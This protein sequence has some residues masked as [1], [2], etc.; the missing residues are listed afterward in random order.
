MSSHQHQAAELLAMILSL[1]VIHF[2]LYIYHVCCSFSY[3]ALVLTE[4]FQVW[5]N[6]VCC[7]CPFLVFLAH[8]P[9]CI[10][11]PP[12]VLAS[13]YVSFSSSYLGLTSFQFI[14]AGAYVL[15]HFLNCSEISCTAGSFFCPSSDTC[16]IVY[17]YLD[18]L[19]FHSL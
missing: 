11:V 14:L 16:Y 13:A 8:Q 15:F 10:A 19:P 1:L 12:I 2:Q 7:A 17:Q 4:L 9:V 5:A 18:Q 6:P 3:F